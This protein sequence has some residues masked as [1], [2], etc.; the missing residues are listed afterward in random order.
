MQNQERLTETPSVC[1]T[2]GDEFWRIQMRCAHIITPRMYFH[3]F[4]FNQAPSVLGRRWKPLPFGLGCSSKCEPMLLLHTFLLRRKT[5]C[6][7]EMHESILGLI[8][9]PSSGGSLTLPG[10]LGVWTDA[11]RCDVLWKV[12]VRKKFFVDAEGFSGWEASAV[13]PLRNH[14]DASF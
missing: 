14:G 7:S 13:N 2:T 11:V 6:G 9:L 5:W 12:F 4:P 1:R 3:S 8:V 10:S